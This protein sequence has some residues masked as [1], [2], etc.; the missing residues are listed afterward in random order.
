MFNHYTISQ[1]VVNQFPQVLH[2]RNFPF[3]RS[4]GKT[5]FVHNLEY[6][7]TQ[8]FFFHIGDTTLVIL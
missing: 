2:F 8:K 3:S 5:D 6:Y 4:G 1:R 7:P